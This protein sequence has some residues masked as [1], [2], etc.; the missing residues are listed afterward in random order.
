MHQLAILLVFFAADEAPSRPSIT[1][2][3]AQVTLIAQVK[4]PARESGVIHELE[5]KEGQ[6]VEAGQVLGVLE[7]ELARTTQAAAS[8]EHDIA[9]EKAA[10][11][12]DYRY[13]QK[14]QQ[15]SKAELRRALESVEKFPK[16]ISETELERMRLTAEKSDLQ[17]DQ[18]ARDLVIAKLNQKL[19]AKELDT[20]TLGVERR[21]I[22]A[23]IRGV[24][25][26]VYRR[27]GEWVHPGEAVL[28]I[29]RIDK[30]RV[31]GFLNARTT[32]R[33]LDGL[34]ARFAIDLADQRRKEFMGKVV[35]VDPEVEPVTGQFRVWAEVDNRDNLL[36][37]GL[38]GSLTIEVAKST[39]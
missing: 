18:A 11:D 19:K 33:Q 38:H 27:A 39:P 35:F 7:S 17:V 20:A 21:K 34:P 25:V 30:L 6:L 13:A 12:V 2:D 15:V 16:S 28:R 14:S 1:I 8:I 37:P 4:V 3:S 26:N 31:E 10:N 5:V 29:V 32:T 36:S 23:P 9:K 24:V 22:I